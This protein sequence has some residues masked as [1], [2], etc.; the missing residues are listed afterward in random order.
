MFEHDPSQRIKPG[1]LRPMRI[2]AGLVAL[3]LLAAILWFGHP[4]LTSPT[5]PVPPVYPPGTERVT[6]T[7][8]FASPDGLFLVPETRQVLQPPHPADQMAEALRQLITGPDEATLARTL[9]AETTLQRVFVTAAGV[10]YVCFGPEVVTSHPG[11]AGAELLCVYAVVDT[12]Q[13]NFPDVRQVAILVGGQEVP[14]LAGHVD[15]S[16]PLLPRAD[17]IADHAPG[18]RKV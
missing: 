13:R 14:T 10:A 12:L 6:L 8:F 4:M 9:P 7:L 3:G 15:I 1:P 11:G 5:T 16:R 2:V 17:L 18:G